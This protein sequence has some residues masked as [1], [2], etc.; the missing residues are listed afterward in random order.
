[1]RKA[2][3]LTALLTSTLLSA[4]SVAAESVEGKAWDA[5][6]RFMIRARIINLSPD[7]SSSTN[8]GGDVTASDAFAPELDF[9]YF[10]TDH[11]AAELIAATTKHDMGAANTALGNLDLG[12][13]WALPPTLTAQYHFNPHGQVRPYV[14]AGLGYV[15][16]YNE[17][18][19]QVND[20]DYDN[21]ISYALQAGIDIG[22][23]D[24]W[25]VN[26]DIKKLWHNVDA[27]I[28]SGAVTADVDLDP[29]VFGVG[30]AY[31]F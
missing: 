2:L 19:G 30:I 29:W 11:I 12:H 21:G 31:R 3:A 10:F 6:E 16:W 14:G 17:S 25:A 24:H 27:S 1:M 26:A 9:T 15:V 28:N 7:E 8:I 18:S 13:V 23:N 22:L 5:K 4:P 20:I